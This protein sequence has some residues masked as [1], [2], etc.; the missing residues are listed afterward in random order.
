MSFRLANGHDQRLKPVMFPTH[1]MG[2]TKDIAPELSVE[3][4]S[5]GSYTELDYVRIP[6]EVKVGDEIVLHTARVRMLLLN[7]VFVRCAKCSI[8][9]LCVLLGLISILCAGAL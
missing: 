3:Q 5:Q 2:A 7:F 4:L 8:A 6:S 1:S 9:C